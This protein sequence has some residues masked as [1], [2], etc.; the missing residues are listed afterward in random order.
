MMKQSPTF[1]DTQY[2]S[3]NVLITGGAGFIGS[4]LAQELVK[5]QAHVRILD[6]LS[7]GQISNLEAIK[8]NI[9]FI[10]GDIRT[11]ETCRMATKDINAIFHC[12]AFVSVPESVQKP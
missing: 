12:A 8:N 11:Y 10:K 4:H 5:Q 7:T 3:K 1:L 6:N 9:E 2:K